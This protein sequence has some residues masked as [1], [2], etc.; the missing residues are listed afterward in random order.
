ASARTSAHAVMPSGD[1]RRSRHQLMADSMS[2][3]CSAATGATRIARQRTRSAPRADR[4]A[5]CRSRQRDGGA[6]GGGVVGGGPGLSP[7]TMMIVGL[8]FV[9][10]VVSRR[11]PPPATLPDVVVFWRSEEHT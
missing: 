7:G 6:A 8:P 11:M 1:G 5:R 3:M 2:V 4:S 10:V 9:V